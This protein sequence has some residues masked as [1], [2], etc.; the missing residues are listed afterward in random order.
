MKK[1]VLVLIVYSLLACSGHEQRDKS[2]PSR[3]SIYPMVAFQS[4]HPEN[5]KI[6]GSVKGCWVEGGHGRERAIVGETDHQVWIKNE[7]P[8][9]AQVCGKCGFLGQTPDKA[10]SKAYFLVRIRQSHTQAGIILFKRLLQSDSAPY[11]FSV[12]VPQSWTKTAYIGLEVIYV[13][14]PGEAHHSAAWLEPKIKKTVA[15]HSQT[16]GRLRNI[17][18]ITA[19]TTRQDDLS[20]YGGPAD[21]PTLDR[22]SRDGVLFRHS[23]SVAYGTTPSHSSLFTASYAL[24]HQ[25]YN[26]KTIL[27]QDHITLAELLRE[28]G[29]STAAFVSSVPVNRALGFAQGFDLFDD[30]F[31]Y[32]PES[33]LGRHSRRQR[34][35]EQTVTLFLDWFKQ[36]SH[37]P[38]FAWVHVFDPHQPYFPPS[39]YGRN[40]LDTQPDF[41]DIKSFFIHPDGTLKG[42]SSSDLKAVNRKVISQ[43]DHA[44]RSLYRGEITYLDAQINRIINALKQRQLY[45]DSL[46]I[47]IGDHGENFFDRGRQLAF[48]HLGL[49]HDVTRLPFIIKLPQQQYASTVSNQLIGNVDVAPTILDLV[50]IEKPDSWSGQS[51]L[52]IMSDSG[53]DSLR[54]YLFLEAAYG[55]EVS[56]RTPQWMFT[57]PV[58]GKSIEPEQIVLKP[59]KL[60]RSRLR[61]RM[62][63]YNLIS[64]PK[65]KKNLAGKPSYQNKLHHFYSLA[66][67]L[68]I[69]K[70]ENTSATLESEDHLDAL[71]ELGYIESED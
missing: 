70:K 11:S 43:V 6:V 44:A 30:V 36:G 22:L 69:D 41:Q 10:P 66:Q 38:F 1:I 18:L 48:G 54:K 25:V 7:E 60:F 55:I 12:T 47:F 67:T 64:D 28:H 13:S 42:L 53:V 4:E 50:G 16:E 63:L 14:N 61:H 26:N 56:I 40:V 45:Q 2:P 68:L 33:D 39:D 27:V 34:R 21:T 9:G 58:T 5:I 24:H 29:Y 65:E 31:L 3:T 52:P 59:Q 57:M 35:A 20:C 23:Y 17:V 46:I 37:L 15:N 51:L 32:D 49:H 71:R 19:D 8:A 62:Q